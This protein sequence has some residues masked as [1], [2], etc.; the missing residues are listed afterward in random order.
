MLYGH[1]V[2][3]VIMDSLNSQK[4][5]II[6]NL[7]T[8]IFNQSQLRLCGQ[9]IRDWTTGAADT[10]LNTCAKMVCR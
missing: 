6:H 9:V 3:R 2:L 5:V 7:L 1:A 4:S 8:R 10:L